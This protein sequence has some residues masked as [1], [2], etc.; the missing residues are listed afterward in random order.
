MVELCQRVLDGFE[1]SVE[2]P[3]TIVVNIVKGDIRNCCYYGAVKVL[4]LLM[5]VVERVLYK[6][7]S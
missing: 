1:I 4:V 7:T 2:W 3:L 6:I 5:K